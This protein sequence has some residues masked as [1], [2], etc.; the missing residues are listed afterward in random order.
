[1]TD[2]GADHGEAYGQVLLKWSKKLRTMPKITKMTREAWRADLLKALEADTVKALRSQAGSDW[3]GLKLSEDSIKLFAQTAAKGAL[4]VDT[5]DLLG[6][7]HAISRAENESEFAHMKLGELIKRA[8]QTV[9]QIFSMAVDRFNRLVGDL[10][11]RQGKT[12]GRRRWVSYGGSKSRHAALDGQVKGEGEMFDYKGQ[13]IYGPRPPGGA[14]ADWSNC[15]CSLDYE[16]T[17]DK[18]RLS[19]G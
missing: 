7:L 19:D 3:K 11:N 16:K 10:F 13:A 6:R 2:F 17:G 15:N 9:S 14:P 18:W 5:D 8:P 12:T 4:T 1:M